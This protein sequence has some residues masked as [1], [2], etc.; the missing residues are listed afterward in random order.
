[1][2]KAEA[3]AET[4]AEA[5]AAAEGD[6]A[7][8]EAMVGDGEWPLRPLLILFPKPLLIDFWWRIKF[9]ANSRFGLLLAMPNGDELLAVEPGK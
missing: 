5:G 9:F 1:M 3:E 7:G 4:E 6:S 8:R 2:R